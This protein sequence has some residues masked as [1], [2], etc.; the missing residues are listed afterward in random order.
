MLAYERISQVPLAVH[1]RCGA[2]VIAGD[3]I[4]KFWR[5]AP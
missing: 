3:I 4:I 5:Q 1:R 2:L